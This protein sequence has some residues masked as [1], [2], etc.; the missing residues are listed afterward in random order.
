MTASVQC[1]SCGKSYG[2]KDESI[3]ARANCRSCG[4]TF[5]LSISMDDT[6]KS[7]S[8]GADADKAPA[9]VSVHS[10]VTV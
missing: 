3:G 7:P 10:P 2:V 6:S 9:K 5:T 4:A 1:P 8:D